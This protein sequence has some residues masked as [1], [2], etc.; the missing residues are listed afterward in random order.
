M[1][2]S[3]L[4]RHP[5]E[6][7]HGWHPIATAPVKEGAEALISGGKTYGSQGL[8]GPTVIGVF[9]ASSVEDISRFQCTPGYW[10]VKGTPHLF[11][12]QY[13]QPLPEAIP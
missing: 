13:W 8:Y 12:P 3:N 10:T 5:I 9:H 11:T 2:K 1:R 6:L 4:Q 7:P